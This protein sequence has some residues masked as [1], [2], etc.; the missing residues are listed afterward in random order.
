MLTSDHV[1]AAVDVSPAT[2][3]LLQCLDELRM[4][5]MQHVALMH[6]LEVHYSRRSPIEHRE[7]YENLLTEQAERLRGEGFEVHRHLETGQPARAIVQY[8]E[9]EDGSAPVCLSPAF[10]VWRVPLLPTQQDMHC[11][12]GKETHFTYHNTI[13]MPTYEYRCTDCDHDFAL[14]ATITEYDHGLD[15]HCPN[16]DSKHVQ[17]RLGAV[18]ISSSPSASGSGG[19]CT[20]GGGCC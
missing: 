15:V 3:P 10:Q 7:M 8:A 19:C 2:D 6:V 16:C 5:G 11:T 18:M 4:L 12:N 17:R 20:P 14:N 9:R 1:V 13:T